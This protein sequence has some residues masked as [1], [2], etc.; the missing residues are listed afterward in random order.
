M[1]DI[2]TV[3]LAVEE[4]GTGRVAWLTLSN[5]NKRNALSP[6]VAAVTQ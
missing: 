1:E 3:Y 6:G 5:P 2:G 4:T